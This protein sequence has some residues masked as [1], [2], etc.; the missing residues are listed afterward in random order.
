MV[1]GTGVVGVPACAQSGSEEIEKE[2]GK[3]NAPTGVNAT[4]RAGQIGVEVT[5]RRGGRWAGL[6]ADVHERFYHACDDLSSYFLC[7]N[8][9]NG[10]LM[11]LKL[12][13]GLGMRGNLVLKFE[14]LGLTITEA[15]A[16][17][18]VT[19]ITLS[20]FVNG[21]RASLRNGR[22]PLQSI[23]RQPRILAH[24]ASP[25]RPRPPPH[26]PH[27]AQT[28]PIHLVPTR[29]WKNS[30]APGAKPAP[31]DP[32]ARRPSD[33]GSFPSRDETFSGGLSLREKGAL[34]IKKM[35]DAK[36]TAT[37]GAPPA[38]N[39]QPD[40]RIVQNLLG[41]VTPPLSIRVH[42]T[43]TID[44]NTLKAIREFQSRFM[45]HPDSR[46][47]SADQR[48]LASFRGI[49]RQVHPLRFNA[50]ESSGSRP[51]GRANLA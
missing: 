15:A 38:P 47:I 2:E 30:K 36:I 42:E 21:K 25:L 51:Y 11:G 39:N 29:V 5:R 4:Q 32:A 8:D 33:C 24:S 10:A 40:V 13:R 46:V 34:R 7:S 27:Q 16:V 18:G 35:A 44:A 17:L 14:P 50:E 48:S 37:V 49:R 9:S 1:E 22:P 6:E 19:R 45:T 41:K 43:G 23:R 31:G 3:D 12:I 28:P 26:H 20:E